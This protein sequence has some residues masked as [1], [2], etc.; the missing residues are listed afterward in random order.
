MGWLK[1]ERL[2]PP[3]RR[4]SVAALRSS[5]FGKIDRGGNVVFTNKRSQAKVSTY[6]VFQYRP[7]IDNIYTQVAVHR[8][9]NWLTSG[10]SILLLL[11]S[12]SYLHLGPADT[13]P[14]FCNDSQVPSPSPPLSL[15]MN[16]TLSPSLRSGLVRLPFL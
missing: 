13:E 6:C 14:I 4:N 3:G 8:I 16:W 11:S 15:L 7:C 10:E 12:E 9:S 2:S 1:L 5:S